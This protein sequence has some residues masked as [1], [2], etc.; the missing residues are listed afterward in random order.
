MSLHV[1][2]ISCVSSCAPRKSGGYKAQNLS[3][4]LDEKISGGSGEEMVS[5]SAVNP[6]S[7][8]GKLLLF[9]SLTLSD[10]LTEAARMKP[11]EL[12]RFE[13]HV[14]QMHEDR[15]KGFELEYQVNPT[16]SCGLCSIP[17]FLL[18]LLSI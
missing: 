3:P 8:E 4:S 6:T 14:R 5:L 16:P 2:F 9:L 11:I 7:P 17:L 18:Y 1:D 15:D 10:L 12:G 13:E